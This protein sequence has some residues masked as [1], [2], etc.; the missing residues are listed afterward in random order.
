MAAQ[1]QQ[2]NAEHIARHDPARVL[3]DVEAKRGMLGTLG[4]LAEVQP[5]YAHMLASEMAM[6]WDD[7]PS[8]REEWDP[9]R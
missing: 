9:R 5:S 7:H 4:A 1:T 3:R 6:A 8:Y 2:W